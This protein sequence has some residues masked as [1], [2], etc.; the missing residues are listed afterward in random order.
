MAIKEIDDSIIYEEELKMWRKYYGNLIV[1][2]T[3]K[4]EKDLY[5]RL[6]REKEDELGKFIGG[7]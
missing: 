2:A 1:E 6:L 3:T 7:D 5:K 4:E